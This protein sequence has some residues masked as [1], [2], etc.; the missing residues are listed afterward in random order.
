MTGDPNGVKKFAAY[1]ALVARTF[2]SVDDF[3]VGNEPNLGRFWFPTFNANGT[4]ASATTYEAAL[5]GADLV[6]LGVPVGALGEAAAA[7]AGHLGPDALVTDVGSVKGPVIGLVA[8]HL[9]M[10]RFVPGH[11][12]A[13]TENSGPDAAVANLYRDRWCILTPTPDTDPGAVARWFLDSWLRDRDVR[14]ADALELVATQFSIQGLELDQVGLC[15]DGDLVRDGD[16]TEAWQARS[17]RG[18]RWQQSRDADKI[19]WRLNT[20]RVLLTRARFDTIIWVPRGDADDPSRDPAVFEDPERFD[21]TRPNAGAHIA[22][23]SG[24]HYCLGAALARMEGEVGLRALFDRFPDLAL[25]GPPHRRRR[26]FGRVRPVHQPQVR[27]VEALQADAEPIDRRGGQRGHGGRRQV[28]RV[29]LQGNFGL[30]RNPKM[31]A[32]SLEKLV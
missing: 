8:P 12:V 16:G 28:I 32:N 2:P 4:I 7:I 17:F 23:S 19:A 9:D 25:E 6:V 18:T 1:M 22:F 14:A 5:A 13:G 15:W 24:I 30:R 27:L 21:V 10:R 26:F 11:P 29:G 31:P 20:Y 3:V